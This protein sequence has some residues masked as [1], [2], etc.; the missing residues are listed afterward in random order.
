MNQII[1]RVAFVFLLAVSTAATGHSE[2]FPSDDVRRIVKEGIQA[3]KCPGAVVAIGFD[4]RTVFQS[5]FGDRQVEPTKV[6]MTEDTIFD[7]ASLTKP[8]AT[9][10]SVMIL[11]D[12]GKISIDDPVSQYLPDFA[13][14]DKESVTIRHLLLHTSGLIPDNGMSDYKGT[15]AESIANLM[16]QKLRSPPGTRFRYSDV[17]FM[18]LGELVEQVSG[19]PLNEFAQQN[20][21]EPLKMKDTNFRSI[22]QDDERCATTQQREGHWMRGEVHDPRC[23]ALGGVAGHAGLFSTAEDLSKLANVLLKSGKNEDVS[24]F[25]QSTFDAMTTGIKVPGASENQIQLRS[26]G[27]DKQSGYSS[28][29]GKSMTESA[30]GHGGF[31]GTAIW[32]DPEQKLYVIFL[33][34]RVHPDG[35]GSVNSLAGEIGTIAADWAIE[36]LRSSETR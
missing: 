5:A 11:A 3:G 34:N 36:Q 33:S 9:A 25:S 4:G 17:G 28:N 10:T 13:G 16:N 21:F 2:D 30:F 1:S 24:L 26:L 12:Q 19:K 8:I 14:Q 22:G 35:K 31:T 32:I 7:L 20:I 29:R 6:P 18:V 15:H 27:W 23:Y